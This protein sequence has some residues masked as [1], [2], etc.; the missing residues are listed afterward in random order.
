MLL[1][2]CI[3]HDV[4]NFFSKCKQNCRKLRI[5]SYLLKKSLVENIIFCVVSSHFN[6]NKA[7][8]HDCKSIP[9]QK[10]AVKRFVN[11]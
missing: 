10:Y 3:K 11:L 4:K 9:M 7:H 1:V 2:T 8:D 5:W 6:Q